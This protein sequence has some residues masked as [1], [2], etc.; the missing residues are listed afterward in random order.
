MGEASYAAAECA[1]DSRMPTYKNGS[2]IICIF[3]TTTNLFFAC[4]HAKT[5]RN[6]KSSNKTH[7]RMSASQDTLKLQ[8]SESDKFVHTGKRNRPET[9]SLRICPIPACRH[10]RKGHTLTFRQCAETYCTDRLTRARLAVFWQSR[11]PA[12]EIIVPHIVVLEPE[13]K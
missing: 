6:C 7:S 1:I 12:S 9:A 5:P 13:K 4:P 3:L 8:D 11:M 10:A 2:E